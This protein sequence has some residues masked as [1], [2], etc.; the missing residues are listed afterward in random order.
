MCQLVRDCGCEKVPDI[1]VAILGPGQ[2]M[3]VQL[4]Q[5]RINPDVAVMLVAL[6][7][8]IMTVVM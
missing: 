5:N 2:N 6:D 1:D 4:V 7:K 8:K 3:L